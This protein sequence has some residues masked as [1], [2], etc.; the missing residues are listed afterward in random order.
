MIDFFGSSIRADIRLTLAYGFS[1]TVIMLLVIFGVRLVVNVLE[2][3][4]HMEAAANAPRWALRL[5]ARVAHSKGWE[6]MP[7]WECPAEALPCGQVRVWFARI[8]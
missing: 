8:C 4:A 1:A 7:E 6:P 3:F 5:G 2:D